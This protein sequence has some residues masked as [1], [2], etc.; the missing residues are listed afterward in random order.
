MKQNEKNMSENDVVISPKEK[1]EKIFNTVVNVLLVIVTILAMV[2]TYTSY[3]TKKGS[4]VPS[5]FGYI[6]L[7]IQSD[8]MKDFFEEGDLV[9]SKT[10]EDPAALQEGDVIT[11]WTIINGQRVL[12][13]H[14]IVKIND[15]G[16]HISFT[17]KG[18]YNTITDSLAVHEAEVVG[19]YQTHV[20][21]LGSVLDFLQTSKGF[22]LVVVLPVFLFFAYYV[23]AF[24]RA[25][26]A[27][28]A[29]KTRETI[30]NERAA[31]ND[32]MMQL[33]QEQLQEIMAKL[34]AEASKN[35]AAPEQ[36]GA[37]E[38]AGQNTENKG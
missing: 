5:L 21:G 35:N 8:S 4:G 28:Q 30:E 24:F 9:I 15:G 32:G 2:C 14:R 19:V 37:G 29:R 33:S 31:Q 20:K 18:D 23:V 7:A 22:F 36:S 12:N 38:N 25:L 34:L 6:P 11:F 10:V 1:R 26:F 27:Y 17:T 13:T 16:T 3:V